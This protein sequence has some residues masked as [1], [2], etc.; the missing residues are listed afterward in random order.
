MGA[1]QST[2]L[3]GMRCAPSGWRCRARSER[4]RRSDVNPP[5]KVASLR[6]RPSAASPFSS[7]RLVAPSSNWRSAVYACTRY[8][9][10]LLTESDPGA[11]RPRSADQRS[12]ARVNKREVTPLERLAKRICHAANARGTTE[13]GA[14]IATFKQRASSSVVKAAVDLAIANDWLRFDGETY[15]L[16]QSGIDLGAQ[17]TPPAAR[18]NDCPSQ[19]LSPAVREGSRIELQPSAHIAAGIHDPTCRPHIR[20]DFHPVA[21]EWPRGAN[22][23]WL[24]NTAR[25]LYPGRLD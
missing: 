16:T 15:I 12:T 8:E 22:T 11:G 14:V 19:A 4:S 24:L 18:R 2:L 17:S 5:R 20:E 21:G 3:G 7:K 6:I 1:S 9:Y 23:A 25:R 13:V 10:V